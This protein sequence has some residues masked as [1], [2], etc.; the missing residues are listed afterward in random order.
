MKILCLFVF[1]AL[2]ACGTPF[3]VSGSAFGTKVVVNFPDGFKAPTKVVSE[4]S[5]KTA[6]LKVP[7]S[8]PVTSGTVPVTTQSGKTTDVPVV[9]A[10]V[11]KPVLAVPTK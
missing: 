2:A 7:A 8:A 11:S 9:V 1:L 6:I 3:S 5:L 4:P 10:D